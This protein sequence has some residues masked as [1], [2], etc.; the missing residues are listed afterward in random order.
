MEQ[1][2]SLDNALSGRP[3]SPE[4]GDLRTVLE[5]FAAQRNMIPARRA[6]PR[7][8]DW[9]LA[10]GIVTV[11]LCVESLLLPSMLSVAVQFLTTMVAVYSA[12]RRFG[13][14]RMFA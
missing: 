2:L 8:P 1:L 7:I 6:Q 11:L 14:G 13:F 5:Q 4:Y 3:T 12:T 10:A 9:E